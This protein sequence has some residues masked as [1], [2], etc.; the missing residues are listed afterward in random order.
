MPEPQLVTDSTYITPK[1]ERAQGTSPQTRSDTKTFARKAAAAATMAAR[2]PN[3]LPKEDNKVVVRPRGGLCIAKTPI[4]IIEEAIAAAAG[5]TKAE[6][7]KDTFLPN[8]EQNIVIVSTPDS[9]R[10]CKYSTIKEIMIGGQ[11]HE[12]GAYAT[13]P[14]SM[15]KGVIR[16]VP[17]QHTQ[18]DIMERIIT[19]KNPTVTG[20]RRIGTTTTV[21]VTFEGDK[22]PN[23]V[24]YGSGV[25]KCSLY[26]K[27][28]DFCT[29]CGEVGHR[30]DVCPTPNVRVCFDCGMKNPKEG[31]AEVCKPRCKLCNGMHPTGSKPCKNKY[32]TPYVVTKRRW[33]RKEAEEERRRQEQENL[34][35]SSFPALGNNGRAKSQERAPRSLSRKSERLAS[36]SISR[37]VSSGRSKSKDRVSWSQIAQDNGKRKAEPQPSTS[38]GPNTP[39][40]G[41]IGQGVEIGAYR[42]LQETVERLSR[43]NAQQRKTIEN[44]ERK[45][46]ETIELMKKSISQQQQVP[47]I[48]QAAPATADNSEAAGKP[49]PTSE[50]AP[51]RRALELLKERKLADRMDRT[52]DSIEKITTRMTQNEAQQAARFARLEQALQSQTES[53]QENIAAAVQQSVAAAVQQSVAA[54]VQQCVAAAVQQSMAAALQQ[55]REEL[56]MSNPTWTAAQPAQ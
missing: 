46:T 40:S 14:D 38:R 12:V 43:E 24:F 5:I 30:R 27:H 28:F 35:P 25:M 1:E 13:A 34:A 53:M 50:P 4:A 21:I 3:V 54:A 17:I 48:L 39:A 51:K 2:M 6:L 9:S 31:H 20:A 23:V 19:E 22:V 36:G 45:L 32:K 56:N 52:E 41:K 44:L 55:L 16:G 10:E 15:T 33:A 47:Q 29:I 8:N 18:E 7:A 11:K 42:A 37:D 49:S 26:R